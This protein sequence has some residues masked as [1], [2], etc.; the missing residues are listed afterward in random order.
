VA[1]A[2]VGAEKKSA[3]ELVF[4]EETISPVFVAV[5]GRLTPVARVA[6]FVWLKVRGEEDSVA[7]VVDANAVTVTVTV[8]QSSEP[9]D[10][11]LDPEPPM[12]EVPF[13]DVEDV[14][15]VPLRVELPLSL[16][17]PSVPSAQSA[18]SVS[19]PLTAND[20]AWL[21]DPNRP[22]AA[23]VLVM[24]E[25]VSALLSH[26]IDVPTLLTRGSAKHCVPLAHS[27]KTHL[28]PT[29]CANAPSTHAMAE[30]LQESVF[31]IEAN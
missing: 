5:G 27:V 15:F 22:P 4:E 23:P 16:S 9:S 7:S 21:V 25:F 18:P 8:S 6:L 3:V 13:P 10:P 20:D 31:L 11:E 1:G 2:L 19:V 26:V 29:H 12:T 30:P 14:P 28:L 24:R 17:L